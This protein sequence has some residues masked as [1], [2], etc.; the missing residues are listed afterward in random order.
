[1]GCVQ[2]LLGVICREVEGRVAPWLI[3]IRSYLP[4]SWVFRTEK[5]VVTFSLNKDGKAS[6][7]PAATDEADVI[8]D[9]KHDLL[10]HVL[11]TR[12]KK[13]VPAG[14]KPEIRILTKKGDAAYRF[15]R[16][17]FGFEKAKS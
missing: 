6:V 12:D 8:V 13:S 9:W 5:E 16:Q 15:L 3:F 10:C 14:E 2:E 11:R 1:M 7:I 17:T 4:Q